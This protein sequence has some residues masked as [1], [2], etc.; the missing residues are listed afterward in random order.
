MTFFTQ[1]QIATQEQRQQF[2]SIPVLQAGMTGDVSLNTYIAFL[3]QAYHHVKHT[4]PLLMACGSRLPERLEWLREAIGEY[5][6]EEM[7]HQQWI[8]NDIQTCGGNA[9]KIQ[10][11]GADKTTEIMIAVAYDS[12]NRLN[13]V[14]FLGMVLVLEGTSIA[15]ATKSATAIQAKLNLP[16]TAMSYLSSHGSLDILHMQ[17]FESL[18][19]Q[20]SDPEDQQAVID[21]A[22]KMYFLYGQIFQNLPHSNDISQ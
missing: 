8:L 19:N 12:I 15:L 5:I 10:T 3:T 22:N 4:V 2:L 14:S 16:K 9:E 11:G 1:L 21:M 7:G 13:P 6:E 20:L 18:M 17:T